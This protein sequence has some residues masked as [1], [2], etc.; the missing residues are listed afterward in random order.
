MA[1]VHSASPVVTEF[2]DGNVRPWLAEPDIL[3]AIIAQSAAMPT[4]AMLRSTTSTPAGVR[5]GR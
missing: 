2:I 1:F 4:S 3:N 5:K